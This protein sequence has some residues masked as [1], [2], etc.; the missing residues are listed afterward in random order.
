MGLE[1]ADV[2]EELVDAALVGRRFRTF[3][4]T[5]PFAKL[6][7]TV[8]CCLHD[9]GNDNVCCV[10]RMLAHPG[11]VCVLS[12]VHRIL[13]VPILLVA[14][15][16]AVPAVLSR[17][18]RSTRGSAD[19]TA[20]IGLHELHTLPGQPVDV[21]GVDVMLSVA[22]EVAPPHVVA[23]HKHDVR[24]LLCPGCHPRSHHQ[25][26][27]CCSFR[28]SHTRDSLL[29]IVHKGKGMKKYTIT[30]YYLTFLFTFSKKTSFV[31]RFVTQK[32]N[33]GQKTCKAGFLS[34]SLHRKT[35]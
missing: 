11:K 23:K 3:I 26:T 27:Q 5:G 33:I 21:G 9:F 7:R 12:V 30:Q 10:Q 28:L 29:N 4:A 18:Q 1:L 31:S 16:G 8:A 6:S 25:C 34:L 13:V 24:L 20:G 15:H 17:H 14:P 2:A 19:G 22:T 35:N 32:N